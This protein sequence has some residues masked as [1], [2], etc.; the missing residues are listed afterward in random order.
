MKLSLSIYVGFVLLAMFR[1]MELVVKL[2]LILLQ[3]AYCILMQKHV[4]SVNK[5]LFCQK[6][7]RAVSKINC[8]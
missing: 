2:Y 5:E 3:T 6:I 7:V 1:K 4:L 8:T